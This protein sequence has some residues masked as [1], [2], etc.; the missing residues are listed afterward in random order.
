MKEPENKSKADNKF[1]WSSPLIL[2]IVGL[3]GTGIGASVQGFW[4]TKLE[5][6]KFESSLILKALETSD[7]QK[8]AK[9]LKFLVDAGLIPSLNAKRIENLAKDPEKLPLRFGTVTDPFGKKV[10]WEQ[11]AGDSHQVRI[12][13]YE[14]ENIIAITIPQLKGIPGLPKNGKIL[15]NKNAVAPLKAAFEEIE[16]EGLLQ[17]ILSWD[18]GYFPRKMREANKL[19]THSFGTAFDINAAFNPFGKA[20]PPPDAK[21]SV[22]KL[23]PIFKKYGF[24]WGGEFQIP[25]G[26]HF[27]YD[28]QLVEK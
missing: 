9:S 21:G 14:K 3:I 8:A 6:Q 15:F 25:D 20:P 23:V 2:A 10:D 5:R 24:K 16:N 11:F 22:R 4:T 18:G 1:V 12:T 7:Q 17:L 13:D 19:G 26:M 28:P 27:I